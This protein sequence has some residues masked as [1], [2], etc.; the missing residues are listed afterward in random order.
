[1][2]LS[3]SGSSDSTRVRFSAVLLTLLF[4]VVAALI[5]VGVY[6]ALPGDQHFWALVTIGILSL[7][8]ALFSYFSQALSR[9]PIFQRS[10][11]WGF[12]GMGFATL[13]LTVVLAPNPDAPF[14]ARFAGTILLLLVLTVVVGVAIWRA[15]TLGQEHAR[16]KTRENW[17][18]RPPPSAFTYSAAQGAPGAPSEPAPTAQPPSGGA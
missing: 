6:L 9:E 16:T 1:M 11:T 5:F 14:G 17:E 10:L 13:F 18:S 15:R 12:L 8:F 7:L 3:G 2:E 4:L